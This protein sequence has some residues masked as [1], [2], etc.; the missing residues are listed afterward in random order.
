MLYIVQMESEAITKITQT[1]LAKFLNQIFLTVQS[2]RQ[3]ETYGSDYVYY[4]EDPLPNIALSDL[5]APQHRGKWK[6]D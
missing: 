4:E 1:K 3:L 6:M 5:H 2:S